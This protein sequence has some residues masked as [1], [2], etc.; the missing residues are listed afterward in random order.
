MPIISIRVSEQQKADLEQRANA[1]IQT[2]SDFIISQLMLE[3]L[4][5]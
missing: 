4:H 2:V 1:N 3:I 5:K